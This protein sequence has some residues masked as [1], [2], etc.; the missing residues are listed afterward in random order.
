MPDAGVGNPRPTASAV[1]VPALRLTPHRVSLSG[2]R[3]FNL[4]LPEGFAISVAAQGLKRVR[5]MAQ[6]PDGRI[7]V[8]DMYNLSDNKRGVVYILDGF[9]Q[10]SKSFKKVARYLTGLRNPNSIAFYTEAKGINW[11]YL[12]LTD[13]LLRYGEQCC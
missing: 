4:N 11:F 8:T 3:S 12:A 5:F 9:D 13:R 7:F 6:S 2:G 10:A 1:T